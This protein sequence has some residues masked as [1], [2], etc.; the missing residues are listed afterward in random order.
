M[1]RALGESL[2]VLFVNGLPAELESLVGSLNPDA[3]WTQL[4]DNIS[5]YT[6]A[7]HTAFEAAFAEGTP[8]CKGQIAQITSDNPAS[9]EIKPCK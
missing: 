7:V 4:L 3:R 2:Q 8:R 6:A 5:A 9:A 1:C